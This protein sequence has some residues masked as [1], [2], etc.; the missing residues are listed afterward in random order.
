MSAVII[1]NDPVTSS[2][3]AQVSFS[4]RVLDNS[5]GESLVGVEVTIQ[6]TDYKTYTDLDGNF[7]F[8]NL[9]E[10]SYDVILS[11]ISYNK[12]LLENIKVVKGK[13]GNVEVKL[14]TT[15]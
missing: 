13:P 3:P 15:R 11:L 9:P 4:G 1:T 14:I 12:S 7:T 2:N 6:N 5:T 8:K 10:G